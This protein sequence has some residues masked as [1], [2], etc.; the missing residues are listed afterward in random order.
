MDAN[1]YFAQLNT[2]KYI[3]NNISFPILEKE[4]QKFLNF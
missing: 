2:N 3:V 1:T 4:G